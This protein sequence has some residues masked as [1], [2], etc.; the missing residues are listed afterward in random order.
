MKNLIN[1]SRKLSRIKRFQIHNLFNHYNVAEHSFR[2]AML[3][4]EISRDLPE[5]IRH[6]L[7]LK[8]LFHDLEEGLLGDFPGPVKKRNPEFNKLYDELAETVMSEEL[9]SEEDLTLWRDAKLG[10]YEKIVS[11][12]DNLEAFIT[13]VEEVEA[14]NRSMSATLQR[15]IREIDKVYKTEYM[16]KFPIAAE[17]V[18]DLKHRYEILVKRDSL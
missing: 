5:D 7:I 10:D 4:Y 8:G 15:F 1:L 18:N 12:A 9:D 14:G 13:V 11:L 3:V 17:I 6:K 16:Q 2:V